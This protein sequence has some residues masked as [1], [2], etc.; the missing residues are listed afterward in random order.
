MYRSIFLPASILA[1]VIIGAGMFALPFLFK[2]VGLMTGF[3]YL[4]FFAAVFIL[5]YLVYADLV[6]RTPGEHRFVGYA[7][8]YLGKAGFWPAIAIG[9]IEMFLV[10]TV[11]LILAPSFSKLF[12][13]D[14]QIFHLLVFWLLGSVAIL[15]STKRV[16]FL[17]FLILAGMLAIIA[18]VFLSGLGGFAGSFS[19]FGKLDLTKFLSAG[20]ILFALSGVLAIPEVVNYFRETNV[21]VYNLKKA[22]ILGGFI[23]VVA[24]AGFVLGVLGLSSAVSEDAV[25]GLASDGI[26]I[27]FL[28]SLGVL[29]F[30]S[31]I[32]SYIVV[33]LNARRILQYDLGISLPVS[34]ALVVFMPLILYFLGFNNFIKGVGFVGAVFLSLES[35]FV[36]LM[37]LRANKKITMPPI[38]VGRFLTLLVPVALLVFFIVLI[39]GLL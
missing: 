4:A 25:S 3:F 7:K 24:Y 2:S 13:A 36:I 14:S 26:S 27:W 31:L 17:E 20:P 11:Y 32:S 22:V 19:G 35:I 12:I 6:I 5:V 28:G 8:I 38:L 10:L 30:L 18:I 34:K 16:A 1:G 21:S 39:N 23:P 29:G 37:W 33:G 9:L 15:F